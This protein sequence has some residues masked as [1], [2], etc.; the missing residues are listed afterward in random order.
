[1]FF[2]GSLRSNS[3]TSSRRIRSFR[4]TSTGSVQQLDMQLWHMSAVYLAQVSRRSISAAAIRRGF[5]S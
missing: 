4:R 3:S 5:L 1:M 2:G